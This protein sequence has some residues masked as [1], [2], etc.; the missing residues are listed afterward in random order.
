MC[1]QSIIR[2]ESALLVHDTLDQYNQ[3]TSAR[4]AARIATRMED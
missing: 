3:I 2:E 1:P 4:E